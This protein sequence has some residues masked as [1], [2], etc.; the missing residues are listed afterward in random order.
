MEHSLNIFSDIGFVII[1]SSLMGLVS[2]YLKQPLIL[3]YIFAG[4]LIGPSGLGF[5]T[6]VHVIKS[7]A[8]FGIMLML[9]L[10]GLEMNPARLKDIG[11]VAVAAGVGQMLFTAIGAY[12]LVTMFGFG[13]QEVIYIT[14]ALTLSSTVIAVKI[15][16]DKRDNNAQYA[17]VAI[18]ILLVQDIVAVLE[19]FVL[20]GFEAG[21]FSFDIPL[22][23]ITL[24]KGI[25]VTIL[26]IVVAKKVLGHIYNYIATSH[27]LLILFSI[28]WAFI[29]AL[30]SDL[31]G[32]SLEIGA[33]I[34]GVSIASFPYTLEISSKTKVLR[35]FFIT[36]FFVGI[37]AGLAFSSGASMILPVTVLCS[38]VLIGNPLIVTTILSLF[39]YDVRTAFFVGLTIANVSEF[40]LLIVAMGLTLGHVDAG[41]VGMVT[42]IT[43]ITMTI[44]SYMLT[45]N[46][47]LYRF[48][49]GFLKI[50]DFKKLKRVSTKEGSMT[51]HVILL[52]CGSMG[53]QILRQV[54]QFKDQYLVVD[55]DNRVIKKLTKEGVPCV[56]GDVEDEDL[57]TE[58]DFEDSE[59]VFSTLPNPE[60]NLFVLRYLKTL[61][62]EKRPVFIAPSDSGRE[63]L[64]LF[65]EGADYV[66]LKPYLG[67]EH[68]YN[69][70]KE[71]YQLEGAFH[72]VEG[73]QGAT[74]KDVY[75]TDDEYAQL[76]HNLNRLRL[77]E[78]KQKAKSKML[79][80]VSRTS[81]A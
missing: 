67:A 6:D 52:G 75:K 66:I 46:S 40:S 41:I 73:F 2:Y 39:R 42:L 77:K 44:S 57:L 32:F 7:I 9:F 78:L 53:S 69:I 45:Y 5:V 55:H 14:V 31:A 54:Q 65:N 58:L 37:G 71:L 64:K 35:D 79:Q 4:F 27:E 51:Q 43:L 12:I 33:F 81:S 19:L 70:S 24:L 21:S 11:F 15:I 20:G 34:A 36:I 61:P 47:G 26:A 28:G 18:G 17:Q 50:F 48:L 56:F 29:V 25:G 8:E 76:L 23:G 80:F 38:F 59:I 13:F 62:A 22:F 3:A 16:N 63:G 68:I 74:R 10:I 30:S 60:D 1:A 72:D 49:K